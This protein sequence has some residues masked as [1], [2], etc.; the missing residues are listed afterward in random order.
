MPNLKEADR[1]SV[2]PLASLITQVT[3]LRSTRGMSADDYSVGPMERQLDAEPFK[4]PIKEL[5]KQIKDAAAKVDDVE[6]L[7]ALHSRLKTTRLR[8]MQ[9]F[10]GTAT[11]EMLTSDYE[12]VIAERVRRLGGKVN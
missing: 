5:E 4:D 6:G 10:T 8:K 11:P 7:K 9:F 2:E 3:Q 12:D 1:A